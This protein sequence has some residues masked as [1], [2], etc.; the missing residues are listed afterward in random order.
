LEKASGKKV[1]TISA[2]TGDNVEQLLFAL[3]AKIGVS[4]KQEILHDE[5]TEREEAGEEE[6]KWQP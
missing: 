4:K 5:K 6:E 2:A 3:L 1:M